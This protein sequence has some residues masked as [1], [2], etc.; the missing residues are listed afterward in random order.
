MLRLDLHGSYRHDHVLETH[1][2]LD[3]SRRDY[4]MHF[5]LNVSPPAGTAVVST[6]VEVA[7]EEETRNPAEM[8]S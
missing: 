1:H 8:P 7:A 4:Y 6:A 3:R 5:V 2:P